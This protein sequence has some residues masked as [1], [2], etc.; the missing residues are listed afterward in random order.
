M[1]EFGYVLTDENFKILRKLDPKEV[2][3]ELETLSNGKDIVLL[4]FEKRNEFCHRHLFASFLE[5]NLGI[6]IKEL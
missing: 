2:F 6:C 3:K 4:C 1:V 5:E